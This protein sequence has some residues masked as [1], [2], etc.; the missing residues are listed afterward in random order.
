MDFACI[1][2]LN[3][4]LGLDKD[5]GASAELCPV[6]MD[7]DITVNC[8]RLAKAARSN[9]MELAAMSY[10]NA[11]KEKRQDHFGSRAG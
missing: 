7:G 1:N 8:F 11:L 10:R 9:P 5:T 4:H 6:D 3:Q 2:D